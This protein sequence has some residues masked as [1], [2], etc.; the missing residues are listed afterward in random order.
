[1]QLYNKMQQEDSKISRSIAL[2]SKKL[3]EASIRDSSSIKAISVLT[4]VFLPCTA[5]A[6]GIIES[7][8]VFG[9]IQL[10]RINT[11]DFRYGSFLDK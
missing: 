2:D 7:C 8:Y 1:M 6:V 3:A 4:M 5:V 11:D 10:T 9:Q